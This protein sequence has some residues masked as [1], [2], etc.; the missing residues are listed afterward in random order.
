MKK[1][2]T[3]FTS[4]FIFCFTY[5]AIISY[6]DPIEEEQK[7]KRI[8]FVGDIMLDRGV[9]YH[10]EENGFD[11]PFQKISD[12][13]NEFDFVV[14]NLEGPIMRNPPYFESG[15]LK[16][17]F[18]QETAK[19]LYDAN[20]GLV[21]LANNHTLNV[22]R[23]GLEETKEILKENNIGFTGDPIECGK[24]FVFEKDGIMFLGF[25]KTFSFNCTDQEIAETIRQAKTEKP[26]FVYIHWGEEY[27]PK[28]SNQQSLAYLMIDSGAD[29]VIGSHPHIIQEYEEYN[30][31]MIFYSLGNFVFDQYFSEETQE[32]L[33][34]EIL[35]YQ[36]EI[37]Y[38]VHKIKSVLS[39]PFLEEEYED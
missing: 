3:F 34:V 23:Q 11:Y 17:A 2:L 39:Q 35:I 4:L 32:S 9:E 25:N 15:S 37:K 26:L 27:I 31:K 5:P 16:F 8:L 33:A 36:D 12:F 6:E 10:M 18:A 22:Q 38:Q 7:P 29:L 1:I 14:A 30:K 28:T 20:I 13:L 24:E 21:S 19:S